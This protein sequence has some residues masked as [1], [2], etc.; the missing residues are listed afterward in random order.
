MS[1]SSLKYHWILMIMF[2]N[3]WFAVLFIKRFAWWWCYNYNIL[4]SQ[5]Y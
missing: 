5:H 2:R 3:G 1:I 4:K